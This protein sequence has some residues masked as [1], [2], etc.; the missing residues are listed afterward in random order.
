MTK[1]L[2]AVQQANQLFP[3][4]EIDVQDDRPDRCIMSRRVGAYSLT[5]FRAPATVVETVGKRS[6]DAGLGHHL[7]LVWQLSGRMRYED[8]NSALDIGPGDLI[9]T[10]MSDDYWMEMCEGHEALVVAFDPND[11]PRWA[12]LARDALGTRIAARAAISATAGGISALLL[13]SR[14]DRTEELAARAMIDLAL[15]STEAAESREPPLL[16]RAGLS[17]ARNIADITYGPDRLARELGMSRR[18]LYTRLRTL[19]TTPAAL[20]RRIRIDHAR[21]DIVRNDGRS[22]LEIALANGYP[23]GASLSHAFRNVYGQAP[24]SLRR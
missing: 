9:V 19:G 5:R 22:L 14:G 11:D 20:I 12:A 4:L 13:T 24:S 16:A 7:K 6:I 8:A 15:L 3:H 18:S 23:D 17:I 10:S 1:P 2:R 21:Q